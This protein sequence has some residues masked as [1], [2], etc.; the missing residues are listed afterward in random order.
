MREK[1]SEQGD[2]QSV[3]PLMKTEGTIRSYE[4]WVHFEFLCTSSKTF[5]SNSSCERH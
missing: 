4:I 2:V 3:C 1:W 5:L